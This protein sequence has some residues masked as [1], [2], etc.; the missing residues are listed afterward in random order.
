MGKSEELGKRDYM[1]IEKALSILN[2]VDKIK[3]MEKEC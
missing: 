1:G 3:P 2:R